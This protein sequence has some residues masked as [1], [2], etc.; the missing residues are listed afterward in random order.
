MSDAD[1]AAWAEPTD[2]PGL[3]AVMARWLTADGVYSQPGSQPG[4]GP[5]EETH[6]GMIRVLAAVNQAGFVTRIS[7]PGLEDPDGGWSGQRLLQRAAVVGFADETMLDRLQAVAVRNGLLLKAVEST[8]DH[9]DIDVL[10]VDVTYMGTDVVTQLGTPRSVFDLRDPVC[11][12]G[13]C[14]KA[15]QDELVRAWQVTLVDPI[16]GRDD[17]LWTALASLF[18]AVALA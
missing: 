14:S 8:D 11:G 6:P 16:P 10:P 12:F 17:V 3:G 5:A 7:Q 1:L 15:V 2:L 18:S 4:Y 13:V 9:D